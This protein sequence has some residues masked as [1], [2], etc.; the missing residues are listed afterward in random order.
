MP[1]KNT[2]HVVCAKDELRNDLLICNH[3]GQTHAYKLPM[4]VDAWIKM[5][6]SFTNLH[7]DC[8]SV[9]TLAPTE[10]DHA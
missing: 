8:K 1:K 3:C 9:P 7:A 6:K 10:S 2:D 4:S 5:T